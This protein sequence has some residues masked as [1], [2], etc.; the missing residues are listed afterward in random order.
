MLCKGKPETLTSLKR[1]VTAEAVHDDKGAQVVV[2]LRELASYIISNG[3]TLS[4]SVS[5]SLS[6]LSQLTA[7]FITVLL[8]LFI[9]LT[10]VLTPFI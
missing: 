10:V 6:A 3:V 4:S 1:H 5:F 2:I 9:V 7:T 8:L